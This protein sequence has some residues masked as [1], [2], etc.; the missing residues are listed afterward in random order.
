MAVRLCPESVRSTHQSMNHLV[1]AADWQDRA[2]LG[3]AA[4]QVV[5]ELVKKEQ[6]RVQ[7]DA[8]HQPI[9]VL[10]LARALSPKM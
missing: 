4:K 9:S 7:R 10:E 2:V 5:P 1:A 8:R 3:A 6:C